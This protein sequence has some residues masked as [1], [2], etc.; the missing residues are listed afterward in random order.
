MATIAIDPRISGTTADFVSQSHQMYIDGRFVN[1]ASGK[2]FPVY[3]PATGNVITEVPEAE[4]EERQSR[5]SGR[6][7]R[8][9][10][11]SLAPHVAF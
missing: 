5:R 4:A 3:N 2:S 11:W 10:R 8:L 9:R 6:A 1:A 7:P